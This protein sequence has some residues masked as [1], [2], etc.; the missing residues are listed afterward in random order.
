MRRLLLN[1]STAA[2]REKL[3]GVL[4]YD[5]LPI[6]A[7]QIAASSAARSARVTT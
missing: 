5:G 6:T 2:T 3:V 4:N 7:R 1:E